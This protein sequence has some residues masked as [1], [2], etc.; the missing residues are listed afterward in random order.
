MAEFGKED[1]SGST[2]DWTDLSGSTFRFASMSD[3]TIRDTDLYR[4]RMRG[5]E[6]MDVDISGEIRGLRVNGVD[7][8][9]YVEQELVRRD[10]L[11]GRLRPDDR[12]G[13][14]TAWDELERLW[15][16]TVARARALDPS[17]LDES[18][19]DEWSFIQTLRH[20]MFATSAWVNRAVLGEAQPFHPLALPWESAPALSDL[21]LTIDARP[22]LDEV[23]TLRRER[24]A[25]VRRVL[26]GLTEEQLASTVT[27]EGE[28][29]PPPR[30][31]AVKEC[32]HV[33]LNEEYWHRQYAERDLA[34][35]ES[36]TQDAHREE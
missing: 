14:L 33:V 1:L 10:P 18:V 23:Q 31:V 25:D 2:F 20:L 13:F 27:P 35:L 16:G 22:S 5:V 34:V 12:D 11:L 36:R 15:E 3:T 24:Q 17:Q 8:T 28:G 30:P 19:D 29:W 21:G 26:D 6:L 7:V 32:L 4:V 9:D